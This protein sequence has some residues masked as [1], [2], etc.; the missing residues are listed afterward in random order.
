MKKVP[1]HIRNELI[2]GYGLSK[3]DADRLVADRGLADYFEDFVWE[4]FRLDNPE[5]IAR[6]ENRYG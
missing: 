3:A 5:L 6:F 4:W 2:G 1:Y